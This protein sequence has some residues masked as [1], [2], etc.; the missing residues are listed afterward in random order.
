[1][2]WPIDSAQGRLAECALPALLLHS[3]NA[4]RELNVDVW[5][6][7]LVWD[8][9][10]VVPAC[11]SALKHMRAVYSDAGKQDEFFLDP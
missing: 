5:A 4:E 9:V 2:S 1:L 6:R 3:L 10:R 7:W 8:P 11:A